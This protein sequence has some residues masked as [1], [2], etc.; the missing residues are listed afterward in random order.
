[1]LKFGYKPTPNETTIFQAYVSKT[2]CFSTLSTA[3]DPS[4]HQSVMLA[5]ARRLME[6]KSSTSEYYRFYL[7]LLTD[8]DTEVR[9]AVSNDVN[10]EITYQLILK[11][12]A[13]CENITQ[14]EMLES[15]S[16][17]EGKSRENS[18]EDQPFD[19]EPL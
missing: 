12:L 16:F 4:Q 2:R 6:L 5:S 19:E 11:E 7:Q 9:N 14:N 8:H 15:K 17:G 1:M 18:E 13:S 3:A 10:P